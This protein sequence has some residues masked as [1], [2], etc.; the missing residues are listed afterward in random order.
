MFS[1]DRI[2]PS[3]GLPKLVSTDKLTPEDFAKLA[4][5]LGI[6]PFK[7]RKTGF[8]SVRV[9]AKHETIETLWNGKESSGVAEPG[10]KIV[11]NMSVARQILRDG[12]GHANTYVIA[13]A[14]FPDLYE[15]DEGKT[16]FGDIYRARGHV[17]A[18]YVA[19]GFEIL[20]PWGET[21][22]ANAGYILFNGTD[23]YGNNKE[24]F[25]RTYRQER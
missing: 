19:G 5:G 13:A 20:A 8:V 3:P 9:A 22:R 6:K 15:P 21:Q 4:A 10:D 23:V 7:A 17:E 14:K 12:A 11:T 25:E 18:L 24:T 2:G 1:L 16:E